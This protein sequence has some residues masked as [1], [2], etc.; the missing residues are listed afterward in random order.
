MKILIALLVCHRY[1][2]MP[3]SWDWVNRDKH[4]TDVSHQI[5]ACRETWI[6]DFAAYADVDVRLF[7]GGGASRQPL[8]DEVFL[9]CGDDYRSL[10]HKTK[11]MCAWAVGRKYDHIFKCDDDTF[12]WA[13]N[14]MTSGFE[15]YD[16]LGSVNNPA[17]RN[18][19]TGLGYWL[20]AKAAAI[21]AK[22]PVTNILEDHWVGSVMRG[23][24]ILPQHD[25]RYCSIGAKFV[26]VASMPRNPEFIAIHPCSPEMLRTYES[27][28]RI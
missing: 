28:K 26:G 2:T 15:K 23:A 9:N 6:K 10:P 17:T 16:Y 13:D 1:V 18:Y 20:S 21:I 5:I 12:I 4:T 11:A 7:Y 3:G 8:L 22:A 14:M 27:E 19:A 25:E 24:G